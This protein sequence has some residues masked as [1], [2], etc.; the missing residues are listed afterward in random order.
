MRE[1]RIVPAPKV[2]SGER[3][4]LNP[5]EK[6]EGGRVGTLRLL[7]PFESLEILETSVTRKCLIQ[8]IFPIFQKHISDWQW[9]VGFISKLTH[10]KYLVV[11]SRRNKSRQNYDCINHWLFER[12]L[13][14]QRYLRKIQPNFFCGERDSSAPDLTVP[15][16][17]E[18]A[19]TPSATL[20]SSTASKRPTRYNRNNS[21]GRI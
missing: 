18:P 9:I 3:W 11:I 12:C 6:N 10:F 8:P 14:W 1:G 20:P 16:G 19:G 4:E 2:I 5:T 13:F 21:P 17:K 7:Q 15:C